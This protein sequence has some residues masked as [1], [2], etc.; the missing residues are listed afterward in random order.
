MRDGV[1]QPV[2]HLLVGLLQQRAKKVLLGLEVIVKH[3]EVRPSL[4]GHGTHR[5][6]GATNPREKLTPRLEQGDVEVLG[7]ADHQI[8]L[9]D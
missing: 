7:G 9:V 8:L 3:P 4:L 5:Q 1:C 6:A 2:E